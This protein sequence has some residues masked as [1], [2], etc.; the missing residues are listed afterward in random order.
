VACT[1]IA[2]RSF[3]DVR[4]NLQRQVTFTLPEGA[5]KAGVNFANSAVLN[6][7][8]LAFLLFMSFLVLDLV[9]STSN[10][11]WRK[12]LSDRHM[13][14]LAKRQKRYRDSATFLLWASLAVAFASAVAAT[15]STRALQVDLESKIFVIPSQLSLGLHWMV[16]ILSGLVGAGWTLL[17]R[18]ASQVTE[19]SQN[20]A[21][22]GVF[23]TGGGTTGRGGLGDFLGGGKATGGNGGGG[24]R[25]VAD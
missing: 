16:V 10:K 17:R 18:P 3:D 7:L 15:Q 25:I 6:V 2:F 12:D 1:T 13:E 5:L 11:R 19:G 8:C 21:E 9:L 20:A 4:S 23:K 14:R 24:R 22:K